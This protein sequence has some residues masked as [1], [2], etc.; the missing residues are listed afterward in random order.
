M[1]KIDADMFTDLI[2]KHLKIKKSQNTSLV[3]LEGR[4]IDET[5]H[6]LLVETDTGRRRLIKHQSTFIINKTTID[7][8][9]LTG[10]P[11][12]RLKKWFKK[13]IRLGSK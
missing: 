12:E 8:S 5:K 11:E 4:I 1:K 13:K 9:K 10:R 6:T 2:G 7:G 3:G